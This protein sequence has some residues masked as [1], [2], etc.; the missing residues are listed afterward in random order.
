[1]AKQDI[2][3]PAATAVATA[4][5]LGLFEGAVVTGFE[6]V[7]ASDLATPF[8][9]ILQKGSPELA[10]AKGEYIQG[11]EVG[12]I[13]NTV[14]NK[15]YQELFVIPCGHR[16]AIVEWKPRETGGG[17]V[18]QYDAN[19][20]LQGVVTNDKGQKFLNGNLLVDTKYHFV[21]V[22][23]L[24]QKTFYRSVISMTSTQLK[25]SRSWLP[26]QMSLKSCGRQVPAWA[27][28]YKLTTAY[29]ENAKGDWYGWNI[30]LERALMGWKKS[31][32]KEQTVYTAELF[33]DEVPA[34]ALAEAKSFT[35]YVV[36]GQ[37][38]IDPRAQRVESVVE[39]SAIDEV[40]TDD[41]SPV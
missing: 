36:S 21:V 19:E 9:T 26:M 30:Q 6:N 38:A 2:A 4:D 14:S 22:V 8:L 27:Q 37:A 28:L 23:D 13:L 33:L 25:K 17:Y 41:K 35:E 5:D 29:E 3:K 7:Q 18:R 24:Q 10:K 20:Q 39:P 1:M 32:L 11:A 16:S 40:L 12:N 31:G 34:E 15:L